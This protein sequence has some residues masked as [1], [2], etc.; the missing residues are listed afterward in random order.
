MIDCESIN[1]KNAELSQSELLKRE[2]IFAFII[3]LP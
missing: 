2:H 3:F 1:Y